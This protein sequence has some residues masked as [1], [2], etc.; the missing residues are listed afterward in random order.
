M[1]HMVATI[2][3]KVITSGCVDITCERPAASAALPK[4]R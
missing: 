2:V 4:L 1:G 3:S